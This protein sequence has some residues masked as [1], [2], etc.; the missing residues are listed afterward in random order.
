M[1]ASANAP[2]AP[3]HR[4]SRLPWIHRVSLEAHTNCEYAQ[5]QKIMTTHFFRFS[6]VDYRNS[7]D[8]DQPITWQ[9]G[10]EL[11]ISRTIS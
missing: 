10:I 7:V 8:A 2:P 1:T 6:A 11:A 3:H 4:L 9:H 5:R